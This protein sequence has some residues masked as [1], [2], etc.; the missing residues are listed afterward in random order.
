MRLYRPIK[1]F[2]GWGMRT[3][4]NGKNGKAY[5]VSGNVG[6]QLELK[7]GSKTLLGTQ[8]GKEAK[9]ANESLQKRN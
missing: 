5:N 7:N 1:E 6:I 2:G 8:K 9:S 4:F 3:A